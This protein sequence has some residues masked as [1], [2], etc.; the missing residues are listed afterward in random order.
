M[1]V[2]LC[3]LGCLYFPLSLLLAQHGKRARPL[4]SEVRASV[5]R[6]EC[7]R[8]H[9]TLIA[10]SHSRRRWTSRLFRVYLIVST[11]VRHDGG[12]RCQVPKQRTTKGNQNS[13]VSKFTPRG[14]SVAVSGVGKPG[15]CC[16][17]KGSRTPTSPPIFQGDTCF[18]YTTELPL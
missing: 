4:M 8:F 5:S 18:H 14:I 16:S 17:S 7:W 11:P 10:K 6:C 2:F 15:S 13:C 1:R 3:D 9:P 12:N